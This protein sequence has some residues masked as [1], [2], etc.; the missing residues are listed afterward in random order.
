MPNVLISENW[1]DLLLPGFRK[2]FVDT[3]KQLPS[4]LD[5]IFNIQD[6]DMATEKLSQV[7][8]FPGISE[9]TGKIEYSESPVQGY[10]KSISH[11]E[12]AGGYIVERKIASDDL[13]RI[14]S[15]FPKSFAT[16]VK[17]QRE[18]LGWD[19]LNNAFT[20]APTDGDGKTL[21]ASDHPSAADASY[22]LDNSG[23]SALSATAVSATRLAMR[24]FTDDTGGK[25]Y[26]MGDTLI[27]PMDLEE[28]G[29]EIV[30]SK[31]QLDSANNNPNFLAGKYKIIIAPFFTST[32]N[33]FMVDS[34]M[35]KD[36]L[37]W[38]DREPVQYFKDSDSDTLQAKY[39]V[40]FRCST[41]WQDPRFLYGHL[42]S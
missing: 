40:Y 12:Y 23:T 8:A 1:P 6:S 17:R 16:S 5:Q 28:K 21:C 22:A 35:M 2:I 39:A 41:A 26:I 33:W 14:I 31:G 27:V 32:K 37:F 18:T 13:Y 30:T 34:T 10:D 20:F 38:F 29:W 24:K 9:F 19:V 7:G 11:T 15:G 25:I 3:Y 42:V 36:Q 4:Q